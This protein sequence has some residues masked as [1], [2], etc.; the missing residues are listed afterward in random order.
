MSVL[1]P[2][3]NCA[4]F[5]GAAIASVAESDFSDYEHIIVDD[6][7]TDLSKEAIL[8]AINSLSKN[9]AS[10]VKVYFKPNTGEADTDN[11]ALEKSSGALIVVLNADDIV[12]TGLLSKSVEVMRM[13]E[14]AVVTYPDWIMINGTGEIIKEVKT[15]DYSFEALIG[16]FECIPG[17]GAFIRRSVLDQGIL[18]DPSYS[19]ISDYECWQRLSLKG[20]FVRIPEF[21]AFWR[22]HGENLSLTSRGKSWADQAIS[23]AKK[24]CATEIASRNSKVKRLAL[25]GLSRAYLLAALQGTWDRKVPIFSYLVRS[26]AIGVLNGRLITKEDLSILFQAGYSLLFRAWGKR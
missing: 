24:F 9:A 19:L 3:Y 25:L 15:R 11:F 16:K 13:H 4:E 21:H 20:R 5:I 2:V 12:G 8:G 18:R 7:S 22:L 10:K 23:V 17:P 26:F 6:G 1:T 14:D